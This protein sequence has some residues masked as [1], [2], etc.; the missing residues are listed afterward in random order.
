M[1]NMKWVNI[2]LHLGGGG[3]GLAGD[4]HKKN[5][6]ALKTVKTCYLNITYK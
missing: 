4:P 2:Y 6:A 3:G 1:N 5:S